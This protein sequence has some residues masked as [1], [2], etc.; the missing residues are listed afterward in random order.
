MIDYIIKCLFSIV[1]IVISNP[2]TVVIVVLQL[3]YFYFLRRKVLIS[4]RDCFGLKQ[5]LNAPII[6]LI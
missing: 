6:S 4:T 3:V 2:Y 5:I 1:F